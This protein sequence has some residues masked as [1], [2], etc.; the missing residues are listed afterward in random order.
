ML[1]EIL[2]NFAEQ[3][4]P[5]LNYEKVIAKT[6]KKLSFSIFRLLRNDILEKI[7][8]TN[9][10]FAFEFDII[11]L[12]NK[13]L[14]LTTKGL[15]E[16]PYSESH[17]IE[18]VHK[19]FVIKYEENTIL[20]GSKEKRD[21]FGRFLKHINA[22][23]ITTDKTH[24]EIKTEA[25]L[26][27]QP[28]ANNKTSLNNFEIIGKSAALNRLS[29]T[30][31]Y[32]I[33]NYQYVKDSYDNVI[34]DFTKNARDKEF[35]DEEEINVYRDLFP[36]LIDKI[37]EYFKQSNH[38]SDFIIFEKENKSELQ[39]YNTDREILIASNWQFER[40]ILGQHELL[41][42]KK[43]TDFFG[44][45]N[46]E[47]GPL[48]IVVFPKQNKQFKSDPDIHD[49]AI[50]IKL[51]LQIKNK[52]GINKIKE[53]FINLI[54]IQPK[55]VNIN[56]KRGFTYVYGDFVN[57]AIEHSFYGF[58]KLIN[59]PEVKLYSEFNI[60]DIVLNLENIVK[61]F[62]YNVR[63]E[64]LKNIQSLDQ[65][66]K[67]YLNKL[68]SETGE[69]MNLADGESVRKLII[70]NQSSIIELDKSYIQ[71]FVKLSSYLSTKKSNITIIC[72]IIQE[73]KNIKELG[74]V[75]KLLE[76]QIHLHNL[77][78]FHSLSM[79][80]SI[81]DN[82][83]I[84][85]YEIYECFDKLS[86]F[87]SNWENEV[88]E[89]LTEIGTGLQDLLFATHKMERNIVTAINNLAYVNQEGFERLGSKIT[90]ELSSINSSIKFNNLLS[91]IQAYKLY[92]P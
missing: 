71:K 29:E 74:E 2:Q 10:V 90:N 48:V 7:N 77:L 42:I 89:K 57:K 59:D 37:K 61:D 14:F 25:N 13:I 27:F 86:V 3:N 17:K 40:K 33:D 45:A 31:I 64:Y 47:K 4:Q 62:H 87:N 76:S 28:N 78:V 56:T 9:F 6:Q 66:K 26:K 8:E 82:D 60:V 41:N 72:N 23:N 18:V 35:R 51:Y 20:V 30:E 69:I 12:N 55:D 38:S 39:A 46:F 32:S 80:A 15:I 81:L 11:I 16:I 67:N 84:T 63:E 43:G 79:L 50:D 22:N 1:L 68:R 34:T 92:N 52:D 21:F 73:T 83:L 54:H 49:F 58:F 75:V 91:T 24:N 88:T 65:T 70:K 44:A 85:F 19:Y 5:L 53:Q 36:T